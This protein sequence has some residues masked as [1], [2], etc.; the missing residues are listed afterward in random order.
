MALT[1]AAGPGNYLVNVLPVLKY[2]PGWIPGVT[3]KRVA[4]EIHRQ[5][6]NV[7]EDPYQKALSKMVTPPPA[8]RLLKNSFDGH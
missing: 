2:V 7:I 8:L 4:R 6:T 5:I 1:A 3:F